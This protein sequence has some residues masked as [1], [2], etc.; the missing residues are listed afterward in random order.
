MSDFSITRNK[1]LAAAGAAS[2]A[3]V[4]LIEGTRREALDMTTGPQALEMLVAAIRLTQEAIE[5]DAAGEKVTLDNQQVLETV[6]RVL[7]EGE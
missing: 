2:C 5:S 3:T 4:E 6:A 1:L 7:E